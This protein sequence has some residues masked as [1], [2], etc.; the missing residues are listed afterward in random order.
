MDTTKD[1]AADFD[2]LIGDWAA[3]I[4]VHGDR[5]QTFSG[6]WSAGVVADGRLLLDSLTIHD[7]EGN[8]VRSMA[9]LR[10]WVPQEQRWAMTFLYAHEP[11]EPIELT[12][13]RVD[14]ELVLTARNHATGRSA[15]VRFY[16]IS[17]SAF[18][19]EQRTGQRI[20][21]QIECHRIARDP[22]DPPFA[23]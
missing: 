20:D 2:F 21:V 9:T 13:H 3:R 15:D 12:G 4:Q 19:W 16:D 8:V 10:T 5:P 23:R 18:R 1:G 14:D 11:A 6:V 17:A 22:Q 7:L